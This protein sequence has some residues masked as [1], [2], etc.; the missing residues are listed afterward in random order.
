VSNTGSVSTTNDGSDQAQASVTVQCPNVSLAK[1]ADAA[2]VNAGSQIGFTVTVSNSNAAGT[3]AAKNVSV[4]DP[5]P[6]GTGVS[7]S[8]SPTSPGWT[9]TG[10]VPNQT[11]S[12]SAATLAAGATSSVHVVSNT[13]AASCKQYSNTASATL[14]NGTAPQN[15]SASTTVQ[16]PSLSITK[17]PDAT[18]STTG[19]LV[20]PGGTAMFTITVSNTGAGTA[21]NVVLTDTMPG[22]LTWTNDKSCPFDGVT[23]NSVSRQRM[24]CTIGALAGNSSYTVKVSATIP[25]NFLLPPPVTGGGVLEIDGNLLPAS[26]ATLDWS[27]DSV[28]CLSSPKVGCDV[29]KPTGTTDDSF[30]QGT[31]EDTSVPSVVAGSIPN[32]K[33]DLQRFYVSNNRVGADD[34]LY[35]AWERVQAPSGTTNMDFELNQSNVVSANGVTPLRTA[36]DIL[37]KYDLAKGGTV[38]GL[39]F[40]TWVTQASAGGQTP[41]QKCEASNTFPCW[42]KLTSL[43]DNPKV[44]GAVN[45]GSVTDPIRIAGQ[46]ADRSLDALTF[47]EASINLQA[48]GIFQSGVCVNFGQAYLKSRSSDSFTSEIKD[49]IAP[50]PVSVSNCP[51]KILDNTAWVEADGVTRISDPGQ[52]KVTTS[53]GSASLYSAPTG[54][55]LALAHGTAPVITI[56]ATADL[57]AAQVIVGAMPPFDGNGAREALRASERPARIL[58]RARHGGPGGAPRYPGVGRAT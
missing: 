25:L 11:L 18:G 8:I 3:G 43:V 40:H 22:G 6:S 21:T 49:F 1:T 2:T 47:G 30:G 31:K 24:I 7:W 23:V 38:P 14:G 46:T 34:Y 53:G 54:D 41:A 13:T 19:Y 15:A 42:G 57:A 35:L 37:I 17:T 4:S 27:N 26:S 10:S 44:A 12:Y 20:Q 28:D 56:L 39:G 16:C 29:D 5:L 9:I 50:I 58:E 51:D 33:S 36:G 32:N 52:I 48:A 55:R 45:T